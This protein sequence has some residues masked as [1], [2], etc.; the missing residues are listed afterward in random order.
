[1]SIPLK[2][3]RLLCQRSGNRCA[4]EG[5]HELL[6]TSDENGG[7]PVVL[8]HV[9]HIVGQSRRGPR[10]ETE[11][12]AADRDAYGNLILLCGRH[13]RIVDAQ[14]Q[15]YSALRLEAMKNAHESWVEMTLKRLTQ[16]HQV[17]TDVVETVHSNLMLITQLP[18]HVY[19]APSSA[20]DSEIVSHLR[21]R[22]ISGFTPWVTR[23]QRLHAFQNLVDPSSPFASLVDRDRVERSR[24][25][26]WLAD[27]DR[28]LWLIALL[29]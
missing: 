22:Q 27:H 21:E 11:L 20:S 28:S 23:A 4:F 15:L 1:M 19:S 13:H 26:E 12:A 18:T 24:V 29:N 3:F 8:G 5:C 9:A 16:S 6:T 7:D 2:D 17:S 10:G 14:P 25:S